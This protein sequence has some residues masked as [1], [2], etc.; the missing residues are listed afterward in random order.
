MVSSHFD[1]SRVAL[2][3][4]LLQAYGWRSRTLRF[5]AQFASRSSAHH[6]GRK[7]VVARP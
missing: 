5:N 6:R 1:R 7:E 3:L 2:T 4:H